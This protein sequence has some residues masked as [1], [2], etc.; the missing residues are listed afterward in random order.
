M[1]AVRGQSTRAPRTAP[2][3]RSTCRHARLVP[4][5]VLWDSALPARCTPSITQET[6]AATLAAAAAVSAAAIVR[7]LRPLVELPHAVVAAHT[8]GKR[9]EHVRERLIAEM[10]F[11]A[12][13]ERDG[14]GVL[15]DPILG[16]TSMAYLD[17]TSSM[18]LA[19]AR[20]AL[21]AGK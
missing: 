13:L 18:V 14:P 15:P 7:S 4:L 12:S 11:E 9:R 17:M 19:R 2:S 8:L 6:G 16:R 1:R 20:A 5:D 10:V 21:G 3:L